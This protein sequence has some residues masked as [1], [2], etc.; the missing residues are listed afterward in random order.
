MKTENDYTKTIKKKLGKCMDELDLIYDFDTQ[1]GG[2]MVKF[3]LND[4]CIDSILKPIDHGFMFLCREKLDEPRK[5]IN[6]NAAIELARFIELINGVLKIGQ[7]HMSPDSPDVIFSV[8]VGFSN[9]PKSK[10]V[11]EAAIDCLTATC[12]YFQNFH[13]LVVNVIEGKMTAEQAF[14]AFG[15]HELNSGTEDIVRSF[16]SMIGEA[17]N[18]HDEMIPE[19]EQIVKEAFSENESARKKA[20]E[21]FRELTHN[22]KQLKHLHTLITKTTEGDRNAADS[23]F[24]MLRL[25]IGIDGNDPELKRVFDKFTSSVE[26][27]FLGA[28][29]NIDPSFFYDIDE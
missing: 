25:K 16:N 24:L 10:Q 5:D 26:H 19:M 17:L 4:T 20:V 7:L 28:N 1:L 23:L 2:Y 18:G 9:K 12:E 27:V 3:G 29:F 22:K 15:E 6:V 14:R 13:D 21:I 8:G 11:K